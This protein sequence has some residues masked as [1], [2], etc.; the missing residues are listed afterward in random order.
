MLLGWLLDNP[1]RFFSCFYCVGFGDFSSTEGG[2]PVDRDYYFCIEFAVTILWLQWNFM[3]WVSLCMD[4]MFGKKDLVIFRKWTVKIIHKLRLLY[5]KHTLK[6]KMLVQCYLQYWL[7][8]GAEMSTDF[9]FLNKAQKWETNFTIHGL[10]Q[11]DSTAQSWIM[12]PGLWYIIIM[13]EEESLSYQILVS[14]SGDPG[15]LLH[16]LLPHLQCLVE[17]EW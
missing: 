9:F 11:Q 14:W 8:A 1:P 3:L 10:S 16:V 5:S 6:T 4:V 17:A 12:P 13:T 2:L 15:P 7:S